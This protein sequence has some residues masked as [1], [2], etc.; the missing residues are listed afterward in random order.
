M[1][2]LAETAFFNCL[3]FGN[4]GELGRSKD[5]EG[6]KREG[7]YDLTHSLYT[8][9]KKYDHDF[10][11]ENF[12][13]PKPPRW[14]G[15]TPFIK[16]KVLSV[17]CGQSHLAVV[18]YD[19]KS[20]DRVPYVYTT[21]L[22]SGTF[23]IVCSVALKFSHRPHILFL[24]FLTDGQLGHGDIVSRHELTCIQSLPGASQVAAGMYHTLVLMEGGD[25]MYSF[26]RGDCGQLGIGNLDRRD[27]VT[28]EDDKG[29]KISLHLSR[30]T[31]CPILV[32]E[33][34]C[35]SISSISAGDTHSLAITVDGR[36]LTWGNNDYHTCGLEGVPGYEGNKCIYIYFPT[37]VSLNAEYSK[38]TSIA[39]AVGGGGF[40]VILLNNHRN[41]HLLSKATP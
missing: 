35:V 31:P 24:Y 17:A 25:A 14:A 11:L 10:V 39:Q 41:D 21:G 6:A 26:G 9:D 28:V 20:S 5:V 4:S 23:V 3:G 19:P 22:N 18:A 12:L 16:M 33:D 30:A 15:S 40:S 36:L 13:T 7:T 37:V 38:N 29:N 27:P 8:K 1:G 32:P 2:T 34:C